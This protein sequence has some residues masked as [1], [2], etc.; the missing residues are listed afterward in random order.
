M[1]QDNP[2]K[3]PPEAPDAGEPPHTKPR[4]QAMTPEQ[5]RFLGTPLRREKGVERKAV[6]S[7]EE[8]GRTEPAPDEVTQEVV[9]SPE[10]AEEV[11]QPADYP[12][13][14]ASGEA[15]DEG[16]MPGPT[17]ERQALRLKLD[18]TAS[19]HSEMMRAFMILGALVLLALIFYAGKNFDRAKYWLFTSRNEPKLDET[20]PDKFPGVSS[21][22]LVAQALDLERVGKTQEAIERFMGAKRKNLRYRGILYRVGKL[23][24]DG[25]DFNSADT[26]FERA[27]VFG[28]NLET[29]N[30]HRGLIAMRRKDLSAARRFFEAAAAADPFTGDFR[31][32]LGEVLRLD[33][34]PTAAI[35][36]YK[37]AAALARNQLEITVCSFKIRM[38][39]L[40]AAESSKVAEELAAKQAAGPL[41]VDWMMT[42]AAL[43][44]RQGNIGDGLRFLMNAR[45]GADPGVFASCATDLIF[46]R[47]SEVHPAV[48]EAT[49]L[50]FNPALP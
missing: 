49:R 21:D 50:E 14:R 28:E 41:P 33:H 20:V 31:Y 45:G 27:I 11:P 4:R 34:E 26:L 38:A 12:S 3:N 42:A 32:Y 2:E 15:I 40:E 39:R 37:Q 22:E 18:E 44:I 6:P 46:R 30:Y 10:A 9:H 5:R 7:A 48:A 1:A 43:H 19:R 35:S 8:R 24:Y 47:A 36:Q 23:A 29:A 25:K 13:S 17:E 16:V